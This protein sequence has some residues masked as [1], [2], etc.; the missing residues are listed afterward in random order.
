MGLWTRLCTIIMV[1]VHVHTYIEGFEGGEGGGGG[2]GRLTEKTWSRPHKS[3]RSRACSSMC[4]D[5]PWKLVNIL[6]QCVDVSC[7]CAQT[8]VCAAYKF[9]RLG[10]GEW[11]C[12]ILCKKYAWHNSKSVSSMTHHSFLVHQ[13]CTCTLACR[14]LGEFPSFGA[15]QWHVRLDWLHHQHRPLCLER[16]PKKGNY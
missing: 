6:H 14:W 13:R 12:V 1:Y 5:F 8:Y 9:W 11:D 16:F 7:C 2:G 4:Q 15:R 3:I 10:G